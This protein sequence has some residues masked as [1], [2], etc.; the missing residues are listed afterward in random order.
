LLA[1]LIVC[2]HDNGGSIRA[3]ITRRV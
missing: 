3:V 2:A 1:G